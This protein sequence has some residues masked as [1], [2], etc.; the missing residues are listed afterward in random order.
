MLFAKGEFMESFNHN[1]AP[2]APRAWTDALVLM[3]RALAMLDESHCTA[4][5]G[6]HLDLAATR[7]ELF[8]LQFGAGEVDEPALVVQLL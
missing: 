1:R 6:A 4:E 3:R 5:I 2:R 8:M 7:L